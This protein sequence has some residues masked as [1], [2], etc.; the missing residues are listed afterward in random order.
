LKL[1]HRTLGAAAAI[2]F[3][4][5]LCLLV[6]PYTLFPEFYVPKN[7]G[8]GYTAPA[9]TEGLMFMAAGLVMLVLTVVFSML[10][11]ARSG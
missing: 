10:Y 7:S 8:I 11:K 6:L 3:I 1:P 5:T 9:T 2:S 4:A